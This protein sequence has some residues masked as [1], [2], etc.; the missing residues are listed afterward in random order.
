MFVKRQKPKKAQTYT[1]HTEENEESKE[2]EINNKIEE[3]NSFLNKKRVNTNNN[4]HF[5]T[6]SSNKQ[7]IFEDTFYKSTPSL[8]CNKNNSDA[9]RENEI[10]TERSKDSMAI[11]Q[12]QIEISK[13]KLSGKIALNTY[14]GKNNTIIY[15]EKS[16][17]DLSRYKITGSI[18]P[19][20]APTNLRVNCRFD[21]APGIC[22]DYKETGYCGFGDSCVFL[23]DRGDYKS[24]W[25]LEE[26]WKKNQLLKQKEIQEGKHCGCH[27]DEES[28]EENFEKCG[29]CG[30]EIVEGVV[31][32]CGHLFCEKCAL[33]RYSN[34]KTCAVCHKNTK[35]MF[36]NAKN[37]LDTIKNNKKKKKEEQMTKK[38]EKEIKKQIAEEDENLSYLDNRNYKLDFEDDNIEEENI[39]SVQFT[40]ENKR[41][42]NFQIQNDWIYTSDYK[43][44]D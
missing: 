8:V 38:N 18:G 22:K 25:E 20:R 27:S 6:V 28:V 11:K 12:K 4:P 42:K 44:Y 26:E 3:E 39:K 35:G 32:L 13:A 21:Y 7:N 23:H 29:I 43:S 36:N 33:E 15:S 14:T 17:R 40:K 2:K 41:K 9:T 31:T 30:K 5:T 34:D 16:E 24:G 10:D 19:M 37:V 1:L